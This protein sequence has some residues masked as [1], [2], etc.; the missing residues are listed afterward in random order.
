MGFTCPM[1]DTYLDGHQSVTD[2][3][4]QPRAGDVSICASCGT[5]LEMGY[6]PLTNEL[7]ALPLMGNRM[8]EIVVEPDMIRA[9]MAIL[10]VHAK[11][12]GMIP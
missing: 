3:K 4:G 9:R 1:C 8:R 2:D 5:L 11:R 12:A 6:H 10:N 7:T